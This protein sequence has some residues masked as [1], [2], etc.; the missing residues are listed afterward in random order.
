MPFYCEAQTVTSTT[1][2]YTDLTHPLPSA[3]LQESPEDK[4][5][6]T[7]RDRLLGDI[8]PLCYASF[9]TLKMWIPDMNRSIRQRGACAGE[10]ICTLWPIG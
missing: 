9:T 3:P 7:K 5:L 4:G 6:R 10:A 2:W 1:G 8:K